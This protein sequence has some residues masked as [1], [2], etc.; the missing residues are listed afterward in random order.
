MIWG[1]DCV[2]QPHGVLTQWDPFGTAVMTNCYSSPAGLPR[3][4]GKISKVAG[5]RWWVFVELQPGFFHWVPRNWCAGGTDK[6]LAWPRFC[7]LQVQHCSK[8][9]PRGCRTWG[10][11]ISSA[12]LEQ[13]AHNCPLSSFV[14]AA[15]PSTSRLNQLSS[16][17]DLG[18]V[19]HSGAFWDGVL[20]YSDRL[21][22]NLSYTFDHF[23]CFS[24]PIT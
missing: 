7:A 4:L 24:K 6:A 20:N 14:F 16:H 10:R 1:R 21:Y 5:G 18:L 3:L 11:R 19:I 15:S 23:I 8:T 17:T 9:E 12:A 13:S 22:L 2:V